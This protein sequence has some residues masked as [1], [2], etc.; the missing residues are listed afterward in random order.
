MWNWDSDRAWLRRIQIRHIMHEMML[1]KGAIA[2]SPSSCTSR[3]RLLC[4]DGWCHC[5]RAFV[6]RRARVSHHLMLQNAGFTCNPSRGRT[7]HSI[8]CCSALIRRREI[9][10]QPHQAPAGRPREAAGAGAR[11]TVPASHANPPYLRAARGINL[12]PKMEGVHIKL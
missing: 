7:G 12:E 11:G 2:P 8:I 10:S 5:L 9:K 4:L 1:K 6:K 3:A